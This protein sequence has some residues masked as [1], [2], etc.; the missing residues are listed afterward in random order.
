MTDKTAPKLVLALPKKG[1]ITIPVEKDIVL[2][3]N[4]RIKVGTG[5]IT[6]IN[7]NDATDTRVISVN[8]SEISTNDKTLTVTFDKE[9][10]PNSHYTVKIDNTAIEDLSGNKYAGIKNTTT[11]FFDTVDQRA[12]SLKTPLANTS[13]IA[14]NSNIIL[15]FD[16]KIQAGTG[17]IAK[18]A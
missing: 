11:L 13:N 2:T 6:I 10:H 9:L 8:S 18:A 15:A 4:E 5:N 17:N 3:F 7:A 1:A 12:P 16:E 14:S